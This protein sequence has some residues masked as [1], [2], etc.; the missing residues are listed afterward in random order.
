MQ[1][2]IYTILAI[3]ITT[4][5]SH[6]NLDRGE[7]VE[8]LFAD[9]GI[10]PS[11][12]AATGMTSSR[13]SAVL[14]DLE[15][16]PT[17]IESVR[18]SQQAIEQLC[19][20]IDA[21]RR[22]IRLSPEFADENQQNTS[23]EILEE[24]LQNLQNELDAQKNNL[25]LA[26]QQLRLSALGSSIDPSL[27]PRITGAE[28]YWSAL[29]IHWRFGNIAESDVPKFAKFWQMVSR[30]NTTD[31]NVPSDIANQISTLEAQ[32]AVSLAQVNQITHEASITA[33]IQTWELGN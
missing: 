30:L 1:R 28:R 18:S 22:L 32:Y 16:S 13:V 27:I 29:P 31:A 21:C 11:V 14:E 2:L 10:T 8:I 26:I 20:E 24:Q 25:Q 33:M 23:P 6:A 4:S 17:A 15:S 9:C 12:W 3:F 19:V 5:T 7:I